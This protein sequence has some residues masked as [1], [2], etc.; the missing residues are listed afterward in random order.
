MFKEFCFC[1]LAVGNRYR[2]HA[3]L[4]AKDIQQYSPTTSF[5]VLTDRPDDF[6]PHSH[7][8]PFKHRL[9][10]VQGYHDKRFVL[11][12]S[13]ALFDTCIFLDSDVR[14][15]GFVNKEMKFLPGI[16]ARTGCNI[17]QHNTDK[18]IVLETIEKVATKLEIDLQ[19]TKWFHEF[20]F[21]IQKQDGVELEFLKLWQTI[22]YLFEMQGIYAREGD[23]MGLAAAKVGLSI[24]FDSTDRFPFFKDNIER[25]RIKNGQSHLHDK[26]IYFDI[27][28]QI[29]Y[30]KRSI[31]RKALDKFMALA[32]FIYRL[33]RLRV[34]A[35]RN[36]EFQK[37]FGLVGF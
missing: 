18:P 7:V 25:V 8:I 4:L 16:T 33:L 32:V 21:T 24:R 9:Q 10:S 1:T 23:V 29:E 27:Q 36:A 20:M 34:V 35:T 31:V 26:Q 2:R 6:K 13:L 14:I 11:E 15:I 22:S 17:L 37:L 28:K 19:E 12:Q 5:V 30:S 3:Q